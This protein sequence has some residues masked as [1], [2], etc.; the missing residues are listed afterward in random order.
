MPV[1]ACSV[2]AWRVTSNCRG[3][4]IF[5]QSAS[6]LTT[7]GTRTAPRSLPAAEKFSI[8][9]VAGPASAVI[10][11]SAS[12]DAPAR[13]PRREDD[14]E[15]MLVPF[16]RAGSLRFSG[17]TLRQFAPSRSLVTSTVQ[18]GEKFH[19]AGRGFQFELGGANP[20]GRSPE[21]R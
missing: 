18:G 10:G 16:H 11:A 9:T 5:F 14:G 12:A 17:P 3:C 4:S 20:S 15:F 8:A 6:L 1:K 21:I 2:S 7:F 13:K 19:A